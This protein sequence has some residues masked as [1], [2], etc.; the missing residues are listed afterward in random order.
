M[1]KADEV[2]AVLRAEV[3]AL[4]FRLAELA[5]L[6][7]EGAHLAHLCVFYKLWHIRVYISEYF[8]KDILMPEYNRPAR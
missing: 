1:H 7:P 4:G 5:V 2:F 3:L 8:K 6:H